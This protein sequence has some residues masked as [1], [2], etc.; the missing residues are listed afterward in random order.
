MHVD[1]G[2]SYRDDRESSFHSCGGL[3]RLMQA[4]LYAGK[5]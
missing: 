4:Y 2:L 3:V 1:A 5:T